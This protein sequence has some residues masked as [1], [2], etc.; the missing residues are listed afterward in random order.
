[1]QRPI[2]CV[3]IRERETEPRENARETV[4]N[5]RKKEREREISRMSE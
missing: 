3:L 5:Y 4:E 2:E 1:M